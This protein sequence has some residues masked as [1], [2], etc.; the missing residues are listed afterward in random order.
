MTKNQKKLEQLLLD[1]IEKECTTSEPQWIAE[2][3]RELISLWKL[4]LLGRVDELMNS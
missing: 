2:M 3:A 1:K 4:D